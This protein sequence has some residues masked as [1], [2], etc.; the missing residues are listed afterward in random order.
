MKSTTLPDDGKTVPR[1][2]LADSSPA[3]QGGEHAI[4]HGQ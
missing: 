4:T 1:R 2:T 3:H